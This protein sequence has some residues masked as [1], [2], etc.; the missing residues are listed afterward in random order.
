MPNVSTEAEQPQRL[1]R[2]MRVRLG[3]ELREIKSPCGIF[4]SRHTHSEVMAYKVLEAMFWG[5]VVIGRYSLV[6]EPQ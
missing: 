1:H 3:R 6:D 5:G 4:E 2:R